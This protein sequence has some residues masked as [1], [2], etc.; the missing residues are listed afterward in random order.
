MG[1]SS[2]GSAAS[3]GGVE[4]GGAKI[5]AKTAAGTLGMMMVLVISEMCLVGEYRFPIMTS[6]RERARQNGYCNNITSVRDCKC[7]M[8]II[9]ARMK[10]EEHAIVSRMSG[11]LV[12]EG[13]DCGRASNCLLSCLAAQMACL[14]C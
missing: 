13:E 1:V 8:E 7:S 2:S 6:A 4:V 12:E 5:N 10:H 11:R 3:A 14:S 9:A